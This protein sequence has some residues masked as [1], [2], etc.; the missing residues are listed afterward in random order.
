MKHLRWASLCSRNEACHVA[1]A[2]PSSRSG[3]SEHTHD[4]YEV[5]RV[6]SGAGR[7]CCNGTEFPL[8]CGEVVFIRP[9]DRHGFAAA[10]SSEPFAIINLAFSRAAWTD[11]SRRY[12][13]IGHAFFNERGPQPSSIL[14]ESACGRRVAELFR[15]ALFDRRDAETRDRFLLGLA[16]LLAGRRASPR[17]QEA[18][19]WLRRALHEFEQD[20]ETLPLGARELAQRAG[21]SPEHLARTMNHWLGESPSEWMLKRRLVRAE[22]LLEATG[23]SVAEVALMSGFE[24]LSNFHRHFRRV[25]GTTPR[26]Y[27]EAHRKDVL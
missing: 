14:P 21:C 8:L 15:T 25:N 3:W 12:G 22:R 19:A 26:L 17:Y 10:A 11:I 4:F 16:G 13:W 5:F 6:D 24:N 23:F 7:H 9:S 27:R 20:E 18:P 2:G 1:Y